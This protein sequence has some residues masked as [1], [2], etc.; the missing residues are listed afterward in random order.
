MI[1]AVDGV[2]YYLYSLA[3]TGTVFII[4]LGLLKEHYKSILLSGI[5]ALPHALL[6]PMV[7]PGYW[8]PDMHLI[9]GLVGF[10]D[11]MFSFLT[12]GLVWSGVLISN[13][14]IQPLNHFRPVMAL[15]RF[16]ICLAFGTAGITMLYFIGIMEIMNP[17][18]VMVAWIAYFLFSRRNYR[19]IALQGSFLFL[20]GYGIIFKMSIIFWPEYLH[21]W[22][23]ENLS[24]IFLAG[25][26]LEELVWSFLYGGAWSVGMAWILGIREIRSETLQP[27]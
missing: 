1:E 3:V 24:G 8:D 22:S 21:F 9:L 27:A 20:L 2:P 5:L 25:I 17:F 26:P 13:R 10:E 15:S 12:G 19:K 7:V 11:L 23:T 16:S 6:S 18:L 4:L 14:K